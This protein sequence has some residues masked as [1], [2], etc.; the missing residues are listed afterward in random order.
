MIVR[1]AAFPMDA[2]A[3][4]AGAE[5]FAHHVDLPDIIPQDRATLSVA[6]SHLLALPSFEIWLAEH[7]GRTV[8]GIGLLFAP[9][10]WDR[11]KI[12]MSEQFIWCGKGAPPTAFLALIR[13]AD[14]RA[15]HWNA[16]IR[17]Y[18][19]VPPYTETLSSIYRR[20]GLK[21]VQQVW[22]GAA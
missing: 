17:E 5:D 14:K 21:P 9:F 8:G 22:M 1:E 18:A 20:K 13:T 10:Q 19:S 2:E 3:V 11:G 7:E 12:V 6:L 15:R 16:T 4:T